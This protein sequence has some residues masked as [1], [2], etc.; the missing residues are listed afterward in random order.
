[1]VR[2]V[3][4]R[5]TWRTV[6]N[7]FNNKPS[8]QKEGKRIRSWKR[9]QTRAFEHHHILLKLCHRIHRQHYMKWRHIT[10]LY[11]SLDIRTEVVRMCFIII[12]QWQHIMRCNCTFTCYLHWSCLNAFLLF[13]L[14]DCECK[15]GRSQWTRQGTVKLK[16]NYFFE[17]KITKTINKLWPSCRLSKFVTIDSCLDCA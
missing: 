15:C 16:I 1:M 4:W 9:P 6:N 12:Q 11:Y 2:R 7:N 13:Q 3:G 8:K 5:V 10:V 14:M 17:E